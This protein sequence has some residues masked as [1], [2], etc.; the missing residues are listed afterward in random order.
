M[1]KSVTSK[2]KDNFFFACE[3]FFPNPPSSLSLLEYS[4]AMAFH[5][6]TIPFPCV[7]KKHCR[8]NSSILHYIKDEDVE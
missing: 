5:F 3:K 7:Q 6:S 1:N 8:Y 4:E 2:A